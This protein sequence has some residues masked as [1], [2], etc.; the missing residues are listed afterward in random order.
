[1]RSAKR[2]QLRRLQLIHEEL[3]KDRF[4]TVERLAQML[5]VN[6]R[7]IR[8]DLE[9]LQLHWNAP[10]AYCKQRNGWHYT[11]LSFSLSAQQ[12]TRDQL[13]ALFVAQQSLNQNRASPWAPLLARAVDVISASVP[14]MASVVRADAQQT[15]SFRQTSVPAESIE[16]FATLTGHLLR[17][18]QI[19]IRY[20]S[21]SSDDTTTRVID[22]WHV[23]SI[24]GTWY[25]FAWCHLRKELRMFAVSRIQSIASTGETFDRPQNFSMDETLGRGFQAVSEPDAEVRDIVIRCDA[26]VAKYVQEKSWHPTQRIDELSNGSIVVRWRL[27]SIIEVS[28]WIQSWG[29]G[30]EVLEPIDLRELVYARA[31]AMQRKNAPKKQAPKQHA[32]TTK[33]RPR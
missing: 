24:N 10:A 28:R 30:V 26:D 3:R 14:E 21:A 2:P 15:H 16:I 29:E 18:E 20:W 9:F 5:E 6:P 19:K 25:L 31:K 27:N 4:P 12:I 7:T 32:I 13:L 23:A 8:R 22:P 1:V 33:R 17:S 11:D